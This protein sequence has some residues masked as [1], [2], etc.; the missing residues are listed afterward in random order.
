MTDKLVIPRTMYELMEVYGNIQITENITVRM[1]N[2]GERITN[3][4]DEPMDEHDWYVGEYV[5]LK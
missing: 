3:M 2:A 1:T 5:E 4:S